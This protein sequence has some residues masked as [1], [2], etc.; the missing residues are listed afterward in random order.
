MVHEGEFKRYSSPAFLR[1][2]RIAMMMTRVSAD[3]RPLCDR[4]TAGIFLTRRPNLSGK[5]T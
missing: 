4:S 2:K 3:D 1:E 5:G